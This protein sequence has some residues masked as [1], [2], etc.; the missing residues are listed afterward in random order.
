MDGEAREGEVGDVAEE[1]AAVVEHLRERGEEAARRRRRHLGGVHGRD[2][3]RV[4][5]A[6]A[7]HEAAGHEERVVR[8]EAHEE[9]AREEAGGGEHHGVPPAQPVGRHARRQRAEQRV[10]VDDAG[11]DLDLRVGDLQILLHEY[12]RAAHHRDICIYTDQER[13][14]HL[15][16]LTG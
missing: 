5:D 15:N 8:G 12:L 9:R 16:I 13:H 10:D 2:H 14:Y 4:A 6:D 7:G 3:E 11:E 1:D